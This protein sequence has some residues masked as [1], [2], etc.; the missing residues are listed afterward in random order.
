MIYNRKHRPKGHLVL[1]ARSP[2][3]SHAIILPLHHMASQKGP[4]RYI[5]W[6]L[7]R[8]VQ[9]KNYSPFQSIVRGGA[10]AAL[11]SFLLSL[12]GCLI[13]RVKLWYM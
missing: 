9:S 11:C 4:H 8:V 10:R 1:E 12:L 2:N 13:C 3:L 7:P 6:A 5:S